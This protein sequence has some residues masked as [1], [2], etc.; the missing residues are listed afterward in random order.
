MS[1][2]KLTWNNRVL[3]FAEPGSGDLWYAIHEVH[4]EDGRPILYTEDPA[5][6]VGD[7]IEDLRLSLRMMARCLDEPTLKETDF[8]IGSDIKVGVVED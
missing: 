4:Y 1:A 3:Q 8:E 2:P 6:V 5:A 7:S